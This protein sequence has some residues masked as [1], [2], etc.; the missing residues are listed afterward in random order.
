[1]EMGK[2]IRVLGVWVEKNISWN[3]GRG[4]SCGEGAHKM[5][6][7]SWGR[8]GA[9]QSPQTYLRSVG[10]GKQTWEGAEEGE[11]KGEREGGE[12]EEGGD[13]SQK[14]DISSDHPPFLCLSARWAERTAPALQQPGPGREPAS[15]PAPPAL[16]IGLRPRPQHWDCLGGGILGKGAASCPRFW[17]LGLGRDGLPLKSVFSLGGGSPGLAWTHGLGEGRG[18]LGGE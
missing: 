1:M 15:Q 7:S 9:L 17:D 14:I 5:G 13:I 10:G 4:A 2:Q 6:S 18:R 8:L 11:R 12:K 16:G 3:L